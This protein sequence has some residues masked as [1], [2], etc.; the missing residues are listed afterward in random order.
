MLTVFLCVWI[1]LGIAGVDHYVSV[2]ELKTHPLVVAII[3]VFP[4]L[5]W[6]LVYAL[7]RGFGG[8]V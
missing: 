2:Y 5:Y 7:R 3:L 6:L 8:W 1:A 4:P